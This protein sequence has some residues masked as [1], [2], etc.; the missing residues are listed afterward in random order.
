MRRNAEFFASL[1]TNMNL[2]MEL[3]FI[4]GDETIIAYVAVTKSGAVILDVIDSDGETPID[5]SVELLNEMELCAQSV[6]M[7]HVATHPT[8]DGIF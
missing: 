1:G 7:D 2:N 4:H 8:P 6:W 3:H 5:L